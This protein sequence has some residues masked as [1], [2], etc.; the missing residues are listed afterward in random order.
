MYRRPQH[1]MADKVLVCQMFFICLLYIMFINRGK[2]RTRE[3]YYH[4]SFAFFVTVHQVPYE[5]SQINVE[6]HDL[7]IF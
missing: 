3:E 6:R 5:K 1:T 4:L 2:Y 7:S